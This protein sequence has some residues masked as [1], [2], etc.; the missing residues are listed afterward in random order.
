MLRSTS[1]SAYQSLCRQLPL[2]TVPSVLPSF[3]LCG[4]GALLYDDSV[5]HRPLP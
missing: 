4:N 1:S 3:L 2:T 5:S